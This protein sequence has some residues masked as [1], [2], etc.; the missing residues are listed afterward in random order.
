MLMPNRRLALAVTGLAMTLATASVA[1]GAPSTSAAEIQR[2]QSLE[3]ARQRALVDG[4]AATLE[5]MLAEDFVLVPPPGLPLTK[6]EYVGA[7]DSGAIDYHAFHAVTPIE[8]GFYGRVAVVTYRS[9]IDVVVAGLGA[10]QTEVWH[11]FVYE[12]RGGHWQVIRE[13]ATA[14]GGFPPR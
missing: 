7:V 5:L 8:V 4:D 3:V 14:V 10:F 13:Q 6:D 2:L 1:L 11:T 12:R 9:Y